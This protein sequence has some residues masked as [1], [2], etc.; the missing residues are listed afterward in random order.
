LYNSNDCRYFKNLS[1]E[2]IK[3]IAISIAL[4]S[5]DGIS[6]DKEGYSVPLIAGKAFSGYKFFWHIIT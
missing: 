1:A 3:H 2:E 4:L 5:E 6:P